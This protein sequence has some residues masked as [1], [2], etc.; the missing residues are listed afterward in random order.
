MMIKC[1]SARYICEN[2]LFV[3]ETSVVVVACVYRPGSVHV[4]ANSM[5]EC[6]FYKHSIVWIVAGSIDNSLDMF[7][8]I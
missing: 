1:N 8:P 5:L 4:Y 7:C 3:T 6:L 2:I